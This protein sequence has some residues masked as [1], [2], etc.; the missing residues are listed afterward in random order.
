MF[1]KTI[2]AVALI[3]SMSA[4]TKIESGHSGV[5]VGF[6]GQYDPQELTVGLHQSIVGEVK[7]YVTNEMT[8]AL[9]DLKPLTKDRTTMGDMDL[10][11]NYTINP[12]RLVE[13]V[14]SYKGRDLLMNTGDVYPM[15][16]YVRNVVQT[17]T[18]DVISKYDA[19]EVNDNREKIRAEILT[20]VVAVLKQEKLDTDILVKQIFIKNMAIN[21]QLAAS[22]LL[23]ITAANELKAAVVQTQVAE[24]EAKRLTMLSG[25]QA[26]MKYLEI[27]N[28]K[29]MIAAIAKSGSTI[30]VIPTNMTSLMVK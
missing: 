4:C 28:Q 19:L 23:A 2:L 13:L 6:S 9:D 5:R 12:S 1:K 29:A 25:N 14:T 15:G 8:V 7:T 22:N 30:Y 3:A 26:N 11:F 27:E 17:A 10:T 18:V 20:Q 24:Q 16:L 21:P